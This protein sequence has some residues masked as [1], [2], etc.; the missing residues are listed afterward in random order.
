MMIGIDVVHMPTAKDGCKYLEGMRDDLSRWAE[1]K[2]IRKANSRTIAKFLYE[3][4]ICRY[5][6]LMLI[7]YDGGPENH[8]L[9]KQL[10]DRYRIRNIQIV[11]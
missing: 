1:Y 3:T 10:L 2:A 9:T 8:G 6:C 7:V 4:W 11:P 5:G